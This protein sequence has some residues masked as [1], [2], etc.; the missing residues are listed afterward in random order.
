MHMKHIIRGMALV[1]F[2]LPAESRAQEVLEELTE[3]DDLKTVT[4]YAYTRGDRPENRYLNPPV[5]H[6]Q[7]TD[8]QIVL[9]FDDLRA[10][11]SQFKVRIMHCDTEWARSGLLDMEYL[12]GINEFFIN[13]FHVSQNTKV[14]YYHY[15]FVV[16]KPTI[17]GNFVLQL[18]ENDGLVIQRKFL[19]YENLVNILASALPARDPEFWKT[20]QQ[21]DLKI[22]L[23][24]YRIGIPHRELKV[25]LRFNQN[26]WKEVENTDLVNSGRN[27]FTLR[28]FNNKYLFPAGNEF[29][30]LDISS[31]FGR[32]QNVKE[33]IRGKPDDVFTTPQL[34]RAGTNFVDAY[35]NDG[36]YIISNRDGGDADLGSDYVNVFFRLAPA[37]YP[38]GTEPVL[39]GKLTD[40][41]YL[42]MDLDPGS[43]WLQHSL[44]LKNGVY[45]FAFG[46]R[47][48]VTEEVDR[49]YFEGDFQQAGNTYEVFIYHAVPGKRHISLIGYQMTRKRGM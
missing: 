30:Y 2:L 40:W 21:L 34:K 47:N 46:L 28:Q 31:N 5:A 8:Q 20:H 13:D 32:G 9:E 37:T 49:N 6:L 36:G 42:P 1:L 25:F 12:Q 24:N 23:G 18:F 14:P 19:I 35:D 3:T 27:A 41:A 15:R 11:F 29:R 38:D 44:L 16:P 26:Q 7:N 22:D 4:L 10:R 17:S 48:A 39:Y 33:I 45:D 43:G